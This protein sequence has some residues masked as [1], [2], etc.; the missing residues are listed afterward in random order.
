MPSKRHA[1]PFW[2]TGPGL[3]GLPVPAPGPGTG[4]PRRTPADGVRGAG[5]E[6]FL[7]P[8]GGA[9]VPLRWGFTRRGDAGPVGNPHPGGCPLTDGDSATALGGGGI[10]GSGW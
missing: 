9:G 3:G 6:V 8:P 4:G 10:K 1:G 2:H 5:G 7:P